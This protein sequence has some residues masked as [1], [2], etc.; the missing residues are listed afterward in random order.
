[1][2]QAALTRRRRWWRWLVAAA[3]APLVFH[4]F[5]RF[6]FEVPMVRYVA[7]C[8]PDMF[9]R[10]YVEGPYNEQFLLLLEAAMQRH[11]IPYRRSSE[12]VYVPYLGVSDEGFDDYHHFSLNVDPK[13]VSDI[14][15]G[16]EVDGKKLS[17]PQAL[18]ELVAATEPKYGPFPRRTPSGE[19]IYGPD[20]RF[21][22]TEDACAFMRAAI[23]KEPDGHAQR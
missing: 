3:A 9:E 18:V 10:T 5:A 17:P 21:H 12:Y 23:L 11:G 20:P 2:G 22:D 6:L 13:I 15:V 16:V 7:T 1:V 19:R 14:A 4:L 8:G